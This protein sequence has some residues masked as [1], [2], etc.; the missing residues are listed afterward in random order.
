MKCD[1]CG[2]DNLAPDHWMSFMHMDL[3]IKTEKEKLKELNQDV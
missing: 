3:Q 1:L 2:L